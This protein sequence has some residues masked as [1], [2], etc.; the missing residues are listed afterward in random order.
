MPPVTLRDVARA[1]GFSV[2]TVSRALNGF[3]DVNESTRQHIERVAADLGYRPN[4]SAR[5]LQTGRA[6]I[7]G[8]VIPTEAERLSEPFFVEFLTALSSAAAHYGYDLLVSAQAPGVGEEESYRR[9][10]QGGRVDGMILVR[11]RQED[12][13]V[14]LLRSLDIPFVLFGRC[15]QSGSADWIDVDGEAGMR[16]ATEHLI[17]LGHRRIALVNGPGRYNFVTHRREGYEAAL[18]AAG[19]PLDPAL[20]LSV[21]HMREQDGVA[22]ME[23]L[24]ALDEPPTAVL[25]VTDLVAFGALSALRSAGLEAGAEV[26]V[27]GFDGVTHS[28]YSSP[29]LTTVAQPISEIGQRIV[30]IIV[31]RLAHPEEPPHQELV[32]PALIVRESSR[33]REG[34]GS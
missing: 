27:V 2:T 14:A 12:E 24:L 22:A 5:Q 19:L 30:D 32:E 10:A 6:N 23:R 25:A 28:A 3:D 17:A 11:V 31:N 15:G 29:P 8:F 33:G 34:G 7:L 20:L 4:L 16:V 9:L 18:A 26:A 13:R 21:D 1:A